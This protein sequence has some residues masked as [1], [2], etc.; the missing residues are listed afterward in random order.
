MV[1][2]SYNLFF[3][4]ST[5]LHRKISSKLNLCQKGKKWINKPP[6][7]LIKSEVINNYQ[8]KIHCR[9]NFRNFIYLIDYQLNIIFI[10]IQTYILF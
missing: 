3:N 4:Q 7:K 5:L 1:L 6:T 9:L 10:L 8:F 2:D